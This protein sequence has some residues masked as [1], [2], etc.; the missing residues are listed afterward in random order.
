MLQDVFPHL[1]L[2][3]LHYIWRIAENEIEPGIVIQPGSRTKHIGIDKNRLGIHFIFQLG[4]KILGRSDGE[5]LI[6]DVH[7]DNFRV[8]YRKGHRPC[9]A[10]G[11]GTE[12]QDAHRFGILSVRSTDSEHSHTYLNC[13]FTKQFRLR[14]RNQHSRCHVESSVH[15]YGS[16]G[17]ILY[18]F[19]VR[20][21]LKI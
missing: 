13:F 15:K 6:G 3:G 5:R 18:R 9:D 11:T 14:T 8:R 20:K 19:S 2:F 17:D 10:S 12:V 4:L 21:S 7:S 1:G 16:P